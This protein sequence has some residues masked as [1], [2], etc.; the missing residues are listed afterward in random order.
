MGQDPFAIVFPPRVL[1]HLGY[2][3]LKFHSLIRR[4]IDEQLRFEPLKE[5]R[6][7]KPLLR[8]NEIGAE[9]EIRFGPDNR[10]RVL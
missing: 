6:N 9:W 5:T 10:F 2:I 7:R 8:E 4:Q 1:D 3:D